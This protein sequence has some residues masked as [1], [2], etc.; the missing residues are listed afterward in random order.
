MSEEDLA[1]EHAEW[2]AK[3]SKWVYKQAWKHAWKH[4]EEYYNVK[5]V[6]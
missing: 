3:H 1:E 2:F 4:C 6:K 5:N